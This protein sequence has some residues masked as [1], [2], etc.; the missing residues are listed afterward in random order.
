[1]LDPVRRPAT[2]GIAFAT[3]FGP[4]FA[5]DHVEDGG[6][7]AAVAGVENVD[8]VLVVGEGVDRFDVAAFDTV[9]VVECFQHWDNGIGCA[10]GRREHGV[11]AVD[12]V[13]VDAVDAVLHRALARGGE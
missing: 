12:G 4:R 5:D 9:G 3:A 13:V 2:S 8:E 11:R 7:S 1:M 6:A 10:R